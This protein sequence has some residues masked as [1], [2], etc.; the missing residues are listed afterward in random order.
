MERSAKRM[1]GEWIEN[2]EISYYSESSFKDSAVIYEIKW[3]ARKN[4]DPRIRE[5]DKTKNG[6]D[7]ALSP[8]CR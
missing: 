5:G 6:N 7:S 2:A 1:E 8:A 4:M 3:R